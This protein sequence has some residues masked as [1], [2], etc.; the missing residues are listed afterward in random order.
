MYIFV[1]THEK[2]PSISNLGT[3]YEIDQRYAWGKLRLNYSFQFQT[4]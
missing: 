2:S 4:I 3:D 1:N